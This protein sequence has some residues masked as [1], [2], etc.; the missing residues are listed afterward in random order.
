MNKKHILL[1]ECILANKSVIA[2]RIVRYLLEIEGKAKDSLKFI[3]LVD[4]MSDIDSLENLK[5]RV[6][7]LQKRLLET[8]SIRGFAN[9]ME[10]S[11]SEISINDFAK[12]T[13]DRLKIGRNTLFSFMREKKILTRKNLPMQEYIVRGYFKVKIKLIKGE[14]KYQP[15]LTGK[16]QLW[17]FKIIENKI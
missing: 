10:N 4:S 14:V 5:K 1:F 12:S 8:E 16:G 7:L 9:L 6:E 11:K 13:Y 15:L 2:K 17:L 3:S